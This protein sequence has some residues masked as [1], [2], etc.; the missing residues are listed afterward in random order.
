MIEE[1]GANR[2]ETGTF[3]REF[4]TLKLPKAEPENPM[5]SMPNDAIPWGFRWG[6]SDYFR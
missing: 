5:K 6:N 3:K 2:N 4:S 1:T